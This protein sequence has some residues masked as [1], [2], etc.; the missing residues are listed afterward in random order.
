MKV[1]QLLLRV[2]LAVFPS[3][4]LADSEPLTITSSAGKSMVGRLRSLTEGKITVIRETDKKVFQMPLESLDEKTRSSIKEWETEGGNVATKF[5]LQLDPGRTRRTTGAEDFDDQRVTL[6]PTVTVKNPDAHRK[7]AKGKLTAIFLGKPVE[8]ASN[9]YVFKT[10]TFDLPA[11][12]PLGSTELKVPKF[13]QAYDRR[14]YGKFGARYIGYALVVH[15]EDG[16]EIHQAQSI[17]ANFA[18]SNKQ[19]LL[20]LK[21]EKTY[22][23]NLELLE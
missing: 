13:S 6:D 18:N 22:N 21:G 17:P 23:K 16:T 19:Q 14:G 8:N 7:T 11:L 3:S 4:V 1:L 5:E 20:S 2:A 12:E 15:S 9:V 10:H